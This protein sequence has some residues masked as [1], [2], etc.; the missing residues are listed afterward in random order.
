MAGTKLIY[1]G[2]LVTANV[3]SSCSLSWE[4][5]QTRFLHWV[6]L[7]GLQEAPA[8]TLLVLVMRAAGAHVMY[9]PLALG[10]QWEYGQIHS[11]LGAVLWD[12]IG[13][14]SGEEGMSART[15]PLGWRQTECGLDVQLP[16]GSLPSLVYDTVCTRSVGALPVVNRAS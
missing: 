6:F 9:F 4:D 1:H 10:V 13:N 5:D 15:K 8:G 11:P 3:Q 12:R 2:T 14:G 7:W 16:T